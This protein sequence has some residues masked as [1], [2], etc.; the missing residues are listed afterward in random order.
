M[1]RLTLD[2]VFSSYDDDYSFVDWLK[3][4]LLHRRHHQFIEEYDGLWYGCQKCKR[5]WRYS[6]SA[7]D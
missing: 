2:D 1:K 5:V 6:T 7:Y 3:C 4:I